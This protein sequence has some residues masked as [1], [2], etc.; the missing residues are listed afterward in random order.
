MLKPLI[1]VNSANKTKKN[2]VVEQRKTELKSIFRTF[3]DISK[4]EVERSKKL[5]D[6]HFSFFSQEEPEELIPVP[7]RVN[8]D[9]FFEN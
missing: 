1:I 3:K 6:D 4:K 7:I 5:F 8:D 9:S 2:K